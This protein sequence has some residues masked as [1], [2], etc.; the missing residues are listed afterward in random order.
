MNNNIKMRAWD[1][2]CYWIMNDEG[3]FQKI[4]GGEV[5][6]FDDW[7]ELSEVIEKG[8]TIELCTGKKDSEGNLVY[9]GDHLK[10]IGKTY[11]DSHK[12]PYLVAWDQDSCGFEAT[13]KSNFMLPSVWT[14][15]MVICGNIHQD[16]DLIK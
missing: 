6:S 13:T 3:C 2:E 5:S 4:F 15:S 7:M 14:E 12:E 10:Y 8:W 11:P 9:S 16:K 1:G